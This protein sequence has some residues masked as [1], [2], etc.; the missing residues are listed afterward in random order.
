MNNVKTKI[1]QKMEPARETPLN[2]RD[3]MLLSFSYDGYEQLYDE[4]MDKISVS[5]RCSD[6]AFSVNS[7]NNL[8]R[9]VE[10]CEKKMK[11]SLSQEQLKLKSGSK[12]LLSVPRNLKKP[13]SAS[14]SL[15]ERGD[16][17]ESF[18]NEYQAR[19]PFENSS[20]SQE[21]PT[22]LPRIQTISARE[23]D[24]VIYAV[25]H[26]S[27]KKQKNEIEASSA[28]SIPSNSVALPLTSSASETGASSS[29]KSFKH[30]LSFYCKICNSILNDPRTL[31]CLHSFCMQC[32][33][34]LDASH[35]LQNN[36]FWRKISEHS[37]SSCE[38]PSLA[39]LS[40]SLN[41]LV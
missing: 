10:N 15:V 11:I 26:R 1:L 36:Q 6:E 7:K 17:G 23:N 25:P 16:E 22:T 33:S 24:E 41:T 27:E 31:D 29:K 19:Q 13:R 14:F 34:K 28:A 39:R 18:N 12:N 38:F 21:A 30:T 9:I 8:T 37:V 5:I 40:S 32:L 35:D 20:A 4:A 3:S 2:N